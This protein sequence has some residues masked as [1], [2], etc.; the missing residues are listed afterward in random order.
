[1]AEP[2]VLQ[3]DGHHRKDSCRRTES[4]PSK[5]LDCKKRKAGATGD[6]LTLSFHQGKGKLPPKG[7]ALLIRLSCPHFLFPSPKLASDLDISWVHGK[8]VQ[9]T[10][11]ADNFSFGEKGDQS[12]FQ[13]QPI[14]NGLGRNNQTPAQRA[15]H[16]RQQPQ[17]WATLGCEQETLQNGKVWR[18]PFSRRG[19]S[20]AGLKADPLSK[21]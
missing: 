17:E 9:Q 11:L 20:N 19:A 15:I 5:P 1:M 8:P 14:V 18:S 2:S 7:A 12:P 10:D 3:A 21:M 13:Q 16:K 6:S 4:P